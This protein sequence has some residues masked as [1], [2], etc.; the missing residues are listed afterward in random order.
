MPFS[1]SVNRRPGDGLCLSSFEHIIGVSVSATKPEISTEPASV[2]ANSRN[3]RPVLPGANAIGAY[4]AVS[5]SV[6]A[7]TANPIS[8]VPLI[9]AATGFMP[10]SMWR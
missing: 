5:V 7:M 3:R 10:S 9:A 1:T 2:S 8:F 4:T 6:M